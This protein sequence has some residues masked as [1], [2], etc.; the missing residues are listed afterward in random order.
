MHVRQNFPQVRAPA[1]KQ[2]AAAVIGNA[3]EWYD[4]VVYGFFASVLAQAFFPSR[5]ETASLLLALATFGAGFCT[6]PLGGLFFGF[7]ADR[8]GRKAALQLIMF[9]MTAAIAIIAFAPT[10]ATIG[11]FAPVLI[12]IGRLL[13]GFATG[14]EFASSTAFLIEVAPAGRRGVYGSLQMVGQGL[15]ILLGTLAGMLVAGVFSVEALH[16][17]AWRLPFFA[18]LLI[19]PVGLYVRRHLDETPAFKASSQ[20][21][22]VAR[23]FL[24]LVRRRGDRLLACFA[25][26]IGATISFYVILVYMPTYGKTEMGLS[27]A[28]SFIAQAPGL[29]L[30]IVLTPLIGA[31]S[32]AIG[33]RPLLLASYGMLLLCVYPLF[34]WLQ[35]ERTLLALAAAQTAFCVILSGLF[36]A[37]ST[38]LAEQ[39]PT[40][41]RT[42]GLAIAYN[43]AVMIF[44]G[45]APFIVA[46]LIDYLATPIAPAFYLIFGAVIGLMGVA[47]LHERRHAPG[48]E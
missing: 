2:I 30:L 29:L 9:V 45:F 32:D 40:H 27:L 21:E 39:F 16:D 22:G 46:W 26:T 10:Y 48:L 20:E 28:Q 15:S 19:G 13:Q 8:K 14:G 3:L 31:L 36:G 35:A 5:D 18:G 24:D 6:R 11:L 44:G 33:R 47:G 23:A 43:V 25:A 41:V 17:W 7:Y 37:L 4:F 38:A 42:V 34:V 1:P 12:V